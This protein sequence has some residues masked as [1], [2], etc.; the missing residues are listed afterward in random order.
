M[1]SPR[2]TKIDF[3]IKVS[4]NIPPRS[5]QLSNTNSDCLLI[6]NNYCMLSVLGYFYRWWQPSWSCF[7]WVCFLPI[8]RS[9]IRQHAKFRFIHCDLRQ[10]QSNVLHLYS[11]CRKLNLAEPLSFYMNQTFILL[12]FDYQ[13]VSKEGLFQ[14]STNH[15]DRLNNQGFEKYHPKIALVEAHQNLFFVDKL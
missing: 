2:V 15:H 5:Y 7:I 4:N 3:I 9:L 1:S 13:N 12:Y 8:V 14:F 6:D 11:D 10:D